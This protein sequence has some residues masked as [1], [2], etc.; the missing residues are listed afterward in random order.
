[1]VAG[2]NDP[3]PWSERTGLRLP[4]AFLREIGLG[5]EEI[6]AAHSDFGYGRVGFVSIIGRPNVGK[7]TFL[8]KTLGYHLAAISNRPNTTRKRWLG[9]LSDAESQI[10]FADTPGVHASS[11]K[12]QE[13]MAKTVRAEI[14]GNDTIVCLCDATRAF[15]DEDRQVAPLAQNSSKPVTLV[16]NKLDIADASQAEEIQD[17][18][19]ALL[20]DVSVFHVSALTGSGLDP[21]LAHIRCLL[22]EGPFLF[23]EDQLT[24]VIEREIAEELI[25]EAANECLWEELPQSII[26]KIDTWSENAKKVKI[27]ATLFVERESQKSIVIGEKGAM[28]N[29]IIKGAR[30]KLRESVDKFV[31]VKLSVK[32]A[33]DWQNKKRFLED[34]RIVDSKR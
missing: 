9:I 24:D 26:V 21:L 22:P 19:L 32:V 30:E 33:L 27:A 18:Y 23:P 11:N 16:V 8:N 15:G 2:R 4:W 29:R 28:A 5:I 13:A 1:M 12:M 14:E 25:R 6:P 10:I 7:S 17:A 3:C 31:D 20:G 34:Y